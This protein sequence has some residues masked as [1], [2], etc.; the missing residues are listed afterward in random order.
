MTLDKTFLFAYNHPSSLV[1]GVDITHME[2]I[3][4]KS[5][6]VAEGGRSGGAATIREILRHFQKRRLT[7]GEAVALL[8]EATVKRWPVDER[9]AVLA[10]AERRRN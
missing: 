4:M 1:L 10:D 9:M 7:E 2:T 6:F 5:L 3:T 8:A